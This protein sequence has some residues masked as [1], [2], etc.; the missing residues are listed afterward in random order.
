MPVL[1]VQIG[2]DEATSIVLR[3]APDAEASPAELF[4]HPFA[5][6][7]YQVDHGVFGRRL[8][9]RVHTMVDLCSGSPAICGPWPAPT[10]EI[11]DDEVVGPSPVVDLRTAEREASHGVLR[12]LL[13]RRFSLRQ[14]NLRQLECLSPL[15]KPNWLVDLRLDT[16]NSVLRVLVDG[17]NG[18]YH[19]VG[20]LHGRD[21]GHRR[22]PDSTQ[23]GVPGA[24]A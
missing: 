11:D 16:G 22:P 4:H 23:R 13:K 7:S 10:T 20:P 14:P 21:D 8:P 6:I 18:S 5:A 24:S 9:L 12:A 3:R 19:P 1:A 2:A 17:L 15:Y